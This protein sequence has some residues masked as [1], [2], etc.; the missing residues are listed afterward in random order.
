MWVGPVQQGRKAKGYNL[1]DFQGR[2][3][4]SPETGKVKEMD[5][6]QDP[7]EQSKPC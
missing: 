6:L 4:Q 7:P 5:S 2:G 3:K 1:E